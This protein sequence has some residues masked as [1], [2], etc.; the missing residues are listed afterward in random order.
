MCC[1]H[2]LL[3]NCFKFTAVAV[4]EMDKDAAAIE[5]PSADDG[6]DD[7]KE[8]QATVMVKAASLSN[9]VRKR[10]FGRI[11]SQ[12]RSAKMR[13]KETVECFNFTVDL[14]MS[15]FFCN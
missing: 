14:V 5:K 9:K 7:E 8:K 3:N 4:V 13:T 15:C 6:G 10:M 1:F 12:L 11:T 2:H